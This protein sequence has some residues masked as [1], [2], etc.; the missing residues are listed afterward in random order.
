MIMEDFLA[1]LA[2][3]PLCCAVLGHSF[4]LFAVTLQVDKK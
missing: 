3:R 4:S 2:Q 1:D